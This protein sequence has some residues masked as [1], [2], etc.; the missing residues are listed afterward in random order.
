MIDNYCYEILFNLSH[1]LRWLLLLVSKQ[2][3]P[4]LCNSLTGFF[5]QNTFFFL[6]HFLFFF[7][8]LVSLLGLNWLMSS[9]VKNIV[10]S[11]KWRKRRETK[12]VKLC[13]NRQNRLFLQAMQCCFWALRWIQMKTS[14]RNLHL[15]QAYN[16]IMLV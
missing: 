7:R 4:I 11:I 2:K 15:F 6:C 8:S 12:R 14:H 5:Y 9:L 10:M 13:Y 16:N 3:C 1:Q